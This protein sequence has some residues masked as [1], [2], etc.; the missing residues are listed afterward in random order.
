MAEI[1]RLVLLAERPWYPVRALVLGAGEHVAAALDAPWVVEASDDACFTWA[2]DAFLVVEHTEVASVRAATLD[3]ISRALAACAKAGWAVELAS[4]VAPVALPAGAAGAPYSGGDIAYRS[5][6]GLGR[7]VRVDR[8]ADTLVEALGPE[9]AP[10]S[11]RRFIGGRPEARR[12]RDGLDTLAGALSPRA[13]AQLA[14]K[15]AVRDLS[16]T[17]S[18]ARLRMELS[19]RGL[20]APEPVL[21]A[22]EQFGGLVVPN[23]QNP[24]LLP[25]LVIGTWQLMQ[26]PPG[27]LRKLRAVEAGEPFEPGGRFPQGRYAGSTLT[28]AGLELQEE[29]LLCDQD[30]VVLR[31]I[32]FIDHFEVESGS[33][34][35]FLEQLALFWEVAQELPEIA[36]LRIAAG[37]GHR[38]AARLGLRQVE[39]ASDAIVTHYR[40]NDHWLWQ[41]AAFGPSSIATFAVTRTAAQLVQVAQWAHELSP[42]APLRVGYSREGGPERLEALK[43]AGFAPQQ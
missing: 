29:Q 7:I 31:L 18:A 27:V 3:S 38:V 28:L 9:G 30:G 24:S 35:G 13:L 8:P 15:G 6:A 4:E 37:V 25:D 20:S 10:F 40:G 39:E 43:K 41:R 11:E 33:V 1:E 21:A 42:G 19:S 34:R 23:A 5:T 16:R 17:C 12:F 14:G 32:P 26:L 36:E 2:S 22:E